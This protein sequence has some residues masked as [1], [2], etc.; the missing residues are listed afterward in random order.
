[1][2]FMFTFEPTIKAMNKSVEE[3]LSEEILHLRS[4]LTRKEQAL[5]ILEG[6]NPD[7]SKSIQTDSKISLNHMYE[8]P[9]KAPI[10]T[11][12]FSLLKQRSMFMKKSELVNLYMT[13]EGLKPTDENRETSSNEIT[14]AL[15]NLRT[16][17]KVKGF[18]PENVKMKG[19][20]WGLPEYFN[21]DGAPIDKYI[22]DIS[23]LADDE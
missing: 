8:Y 4:I 12:I 5:A 21:N 18:K 7:L 22:P 1:M 17:G 13:K 14:N 11:K 15:S 23:Q 3:I 6:N 9:R 10:K 2:V 16:A 19:G 20:L